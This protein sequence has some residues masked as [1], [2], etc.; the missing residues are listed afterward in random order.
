MSDGVRCRKAE[1]ASLASEIN[2]VSLDV[3][4]SVD[5]LEF[6]ADDNNATRCASFSRLILAMILKI[7][8]FQEYKQA[9]R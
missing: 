2:I 4:R 7:R 3:S 8:K 6:A 5:C 9:T 1:Y